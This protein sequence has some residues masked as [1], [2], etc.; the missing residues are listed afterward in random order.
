MLC[1]KTGPRYS[2]AAIQTFKDG[3]SSQAFTSGPEHGVT[4][5]Q[6]RLAN[7]AQPGLGGMSI[8]EWYNSLP[9][10]TS[11]ATVSQIDGSPLLLG[12]GPIGGHHSSGKHTFWR[13]SWKVCEDGDILDQYLGVV[14]SKAMNPLYLHG[15][16]INANMVDYE[17]RDEEVA[18]FLIGMI[19]MKVKAVVACGFTNAHE[20]SNI[21]TLTDMK[22]YLKPKSAAAMQDIGFGGGRA[23]HVHPSYSKGAPRDFFNYFGCCDGDDGIQWKTIERTSS[24]CTRKRAHISGLTIT[25]TCLVKDVEHKPMDSSYKV[26][27]YRLQI[28]WREGRLWWGQKKEAE[29]RVMHVVAMD[30]MPLQLTRKQVRILY[31]IVAGTE[32]MDSVGLG[33]QGR[34]HRVFVHCHAGVGR[35]GDMAMGLTEILCDSTPSD[36]KEKLLWLRKFR[37][38]AVQTP[39]QLIDGLQLA[40]TILDEVYERA[41]YMP[42]QLLAEQ[43]SKN[44][45]RMQ[46]NQDAYEQGVLNEKSSQSKPGSLLKAVAQ[47][48]ANND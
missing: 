30:Q 26:A 15:T 43:L 18:A 39:E 34:G 44:R 12:N 41:K 47:Q 1:S 27:S 42:L 11:P 10:D 45:E 2:P 6:I 32:T 40:A 46:R 14:R 21:K 37:K 22:P 24:G 20:E 38:G 25:S 4:R 29:I 16:D 9:I 28:S 23:S 48:K 13:D 35:T 7:A 17:A 31:N 36:P 8:R 33:F 19:E 5:W 3:E